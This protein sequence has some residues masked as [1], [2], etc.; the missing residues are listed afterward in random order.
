VDGPAMTDMIHL[1]RDRGTVIDGTFNLWMSSRS[2]V[3][4]AV[5]GIP[6]ARFDSLAS[7][8]DANYLRVIKRLH[9][10]GVT[11]VPGTDGSSYNAELEVYEQAG[12]PAPE[13]LRIATII[14]ARVMGEAGDFGSL[15]VGKVAD[16][17]IVNGRPT[18]RVADLR[19]VDL[20]IRAGRAYEPR[21]LRAAVTAGAGN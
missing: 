18:E 11:I 9:D 21:V 13:V 5:T 14:P 10:A 7:R 15:A 4:P 17:I 3:G 8:S 1:F 20:V 16:V 19:N 12:I 2:T 6:A